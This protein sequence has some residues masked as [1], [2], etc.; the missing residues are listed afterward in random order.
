MKIRLHRILYRIFAAMPEWLRRHCEVVVY[1]ACGLKSHNT[2]LRAGA[3][4]YY[5]LM[6][7]VP[8]LALI[9]AIVKGFGL[10]DGL[11]E[12]LYSFFPQSPATVDYIVTF[13]QNALARTQESLVALV[14]IVT[15]FWAVMRVFGS[16]EDALNHIWE[17]RI[18]RSVTR[19]YADYISVVVTVPI[20]WV[21]SC[22]FA[23]Y[24]EEWLGFRPSVLQEWLSGA[25]SLA[26]T[27]AVFALV[28]YVG[29][30]TRVRFRAA[31]T[32][33][34]VAGSV[35]MVFQWV[36]VRSQ[37][38]LS[39][40]NAI[41]GSL[42]ALPLFLIWMQLSWVIFL[43]GAELSFAYQNIERFTEERESLFASHDQRR[44]IMLAVMLVVSESLCEGRCPVSAAVIR[45]RLELPSRIVSDIL[46]SL[47][48]A[49]LL[50]R[51]VDADGEDAY[52]PARDIAVL[53]VYDVLDAVERQSRHSSPARADAN[54]PLHVLCGIIGS[55][56]RR[57]SQ[58]DDRRSGSR[59]N[60]YVQRMGDI[61]DSVKRHARHA[62][63]NL[64]LARL[65]AQPT[66][67]D[68]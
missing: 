41:Y 7:V 36:Y 4:T 62:D 53:T 30:N 19:R 25:V 51:T 15:L 5:T 24:T 52:T 55:A 13:S 11:I 48:S 54:A 66:D 39:S 14:G 60:P 49:G 16:V 8:L 3:L 57:D 58:S 23:G 44:K 67:A 10:M 46:F 22:T 42:A 37:I 12:N 59:T 26:V 9:F 6:S 63:D 34:V 33:A 20:L 31:L 40:Y 17:V 28:Y 27:W 29:P 47:E 1:T 61:V 64:T 2:M 65:A 32:A 38:F 56:R 68:R 18:P 35:F 21:I 50:S 43:T 45:R